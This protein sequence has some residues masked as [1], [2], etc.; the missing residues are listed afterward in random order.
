[1]SVGSPW[2]PFSSPSNVI[3]SQRLPLAQE[4][5]KGDDGIDDVLAS[6]AGFQLVRFYRAF[7]SLLTPISMLFAFFRVLFVETPFKNV[8]SIL[9]MHQKR[10][11]F[12]LSSMCAG[13][14]IACCLRLAAGA[15]HLSSLSRQ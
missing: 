14:R 12:K 2:Q 1:M 15:R 10:S 9:G 5:Y 8:K 3:L 13:G 11:S 4:S 7:C 6:R